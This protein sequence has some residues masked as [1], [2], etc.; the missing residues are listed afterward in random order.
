MAAVKGFKQK[1]HITGT[2]RKGQR[3]GKW[4]NEHNPSKELTEQSARSKN[5]SSIQC[6]IWQK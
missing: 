6:V 3:L 1:I 5:T 2:L 4:K